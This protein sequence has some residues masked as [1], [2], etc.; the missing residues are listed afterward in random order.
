M[1]SVILLAAGMSRRMGAQ[2]K[3]LLPLGDSTIVETTLENITAAE[4]GEVVVVTGYEPQQ[5][6]VLLEGKGVRL[7]HN[8]DFASGMTTSIQ[9]GVR[10]AS[11]ETSGFM[12]CLA[13]MP[14]ILPDEYRHLAQLF[15]QHLAVNPALIVQAYS[16][17]KPGNPVIFSA[18]Y[19][20]EILNLTW[21][22]GCKPIVQANRAAVFPV[23]FATDHFIIDL[24]T[25]EDY[26]M[27]SPLLV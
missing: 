5:V 20:A 26:Q 16:G 19:R 11:P 21:L 25:P 10:A 2:N 3:M 1:L 8:P 6:R 24:D 7:V 12:I 22:E 9:A 23:N 27:L 15:A 14:L 13:D 4:I 18:Q 17:K